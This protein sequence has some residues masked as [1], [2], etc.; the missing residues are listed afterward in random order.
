MHVKTQDGGGFSVLSTHNRMAIADDGVLR[1]DKYEDDKHKPQPLAG[2]KP[3]VPPRKIPLPGEPA[4]KSKSSQ[5][6]SNYISTT[7]YSLATFLPLGLLYQ[8]YRF[9]NIY[10]LFV[11]V[12]QC[13][14]I[15][16]PLHPITAVVPMVFVLTVSMIRE[17]VEDFFRYRDDEK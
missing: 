4:K 7:K 15:V 13:I 1:N 17:G 6:E 14:P 16:S 10:F 8:F 11:T 2:K 3:K 5:Y 12:L 9:S